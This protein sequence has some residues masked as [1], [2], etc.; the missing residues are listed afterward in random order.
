MLYILS[1][2]IIKKRSPERPTTGSY[3]DKNLHGTMNGGKAR[4]VAA[5][6]LKNSFPNSSVVVTTF[7]QNEGPVSWAKLALEYLE[8][9]GIDKEKIIVQEKSYS[10]FTE[11]VEL[12]RLIVEKE[13]KNVAIITNEFQ[14]P[15]ASA[16]LKHINDLHDPNGYWQKTEVQEALI[17][18]KE[19]R[20]VKVNFVSTEKV[21]PFIDNRYE[22]IINDAKKSPEWEETVQRENEGARQINSGEYWKNRPA[23]LVKQ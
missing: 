8:G 12:I 18:F 13:W 4:I 23:T 5:K 11:L 20:D 16:M 9:S 7:I 22:K 10:T 15:R 6:E 14:I 19:M 21:L 17:K 2:S 1:S 3:G